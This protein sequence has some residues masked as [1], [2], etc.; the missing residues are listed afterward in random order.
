MQHTG[1]RPRIFH[2][3]PSNRWLLGGIFIVMLLAN[4]AGYVFNLY[5]RFV[6]FDKVL[7]G[8]SLFALTLLVG[9]WAYHRVLTGYKDHK[10]LLILII[11][12][13]GVAIGAWWEIAEW[14]FD[15]FVAGNVIKGKF[16]TMTD[17]IV[18]TLGALV[19]GLVA[20]WMLDA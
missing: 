15:Q 18:D 16:D 3:S 4:I 6:W 5:A 14:T 10:V 1:D 13:I 12:C 17:L 20:L 2:T 8:Y 7:H 9:L 11:A 19:A